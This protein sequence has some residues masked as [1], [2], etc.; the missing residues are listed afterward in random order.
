MNYI[1]QEVMGGVNVS[2][3]NMK[4][5]INHG[6]TGA[7]KITIPRLHQQAKNTVFKHFKEYGSWKGQYL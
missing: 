1:L 2:A 4:T 5:I 7:D 6:V 3:L